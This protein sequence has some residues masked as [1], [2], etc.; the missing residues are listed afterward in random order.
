MGSKKKKNKRS[1]REKD[2]RVWRVEEK[3]KD[4][5][6]PEYMITNQKIDDES[7]NK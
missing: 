2:K 4:I 6:F 1:E 3:P 5:K 7:T